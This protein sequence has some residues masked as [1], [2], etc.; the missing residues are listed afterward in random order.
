MTDMQDT[1]H[2]QDVSYTQ[3][4][5][6]TFD[7]PA[8][9]DTPNL[10]DGRQRWLA[11]VCR[12]MQIMAWAGLVGTLGA[13]AIGFLIAVLGGVI[14]DLWMA[15]FWAVAC[16]FIVLIGLMALTRKT[17]VGAATAR[18]AAF[19]R[20]VRIFGVLSFLAHFAS[21]GL[22]YAALRT[23]FGQVVDLGSGSIGLAADVLVLLFVA[24][25]LLC[26][27][28]RGLGR[29]VQWIAFVELGIALA[30]FPATY[31]I[32]HF[33]GP[34]SPAFKGY[35]R[36]VGGINFLLP[37]LVCWCLVAAA[38]KLRQVTEGRCLNCGYVL[39][40]TTRCSE[41]GMVSGQ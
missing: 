35:A 8:T 3:G 40:E 15:R 14:T 5:P 41:C 25:L 13:N 9:P 21:A 1:P 38:R 12:G 19:A 28:A 4:P 37:I 26:F 20:I 29:V 27:C 10:P 36:A 17:P 39:Y 2:T 33:T 23:V 16:H 34:N 30:H 6:D 31:L 7:M 24:E 18:R 22:G 11:D 32:M